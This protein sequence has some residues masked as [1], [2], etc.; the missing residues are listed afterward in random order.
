MKKTKNLL[1]LLLFTI[2]TVS[3]SQSDFNL[4]SSEI[5]WVGKKIT[6]QSHTGTLKF[7]TAKLEIDSNSNITGQ[8]QVDMNSLTNTDLSGERKQKLEGHLKSDDFFSVEKHPEALLVITKVNSQ[9]N[10]TYEVTGNL[11]IKGIT[12]PVD[13]EL[14]VFDDKIESKLIF[15]RSK[16]DVQFASGS[17]F[18]NLGDNLIY[19]EIELEIILN[20]I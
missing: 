17:F 6:N 14:Q 13:F 12:H 3:F 15:D 19:D 1:T 9:K 18:E 20:K 5:K 16:Y 11:T 2:T 7:K 8:F 10:N 4:K